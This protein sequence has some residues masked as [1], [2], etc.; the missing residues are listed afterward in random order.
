MMIVP[1]TE[2]WRA[3]GVGGGLDKDCDNTLLP[4]KIV[5]V[6]GKRPSLDI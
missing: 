6:S 3:M 5:I 1:S 2:R 4:N